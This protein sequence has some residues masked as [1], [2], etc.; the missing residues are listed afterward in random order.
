V[1]PVARRL[2]TVAAAVLVAACANGPTPEQVAANPTST[3]L[4]YHRTATRTGD[5][6][7]S[8][9]FLAGTLH[10]RW[11]ATLDGAVYGE[12]ILVGSTTIAVT[13]NNT[14]YGL[15][16]STGRTLWSR[17]LGTPVP[18][19]AQPCGNINPLGITSTPTY[20]PTTGSLFVVTETTGGV[21]TLWALT[22]TNGAI[23]WHRNLDVL[24]NRDRKAE[25]QRSALLVTG[26]RV[27]TSFGG[28][29]GDCGNYVGYITSVPTSGSGAT[30]YY[31]VPTA[32][33]AGM[34]AAGGPAL[35]SNGIVYVASGN[36][37]ATSP[38]YDGSDSVIALN[39]TTMKRTAIFAPSTWADDNARDL[40]LGSLS[41]VPIAGKILIA[42][43]RGV[44]YL[45]PRTLGGIGGQL[46]SRSG[47]TSFGG[48]AVRGQVVYL[49][50]QEGLRA[51]KVGSASLSFLW[52]A[53]GIPGSPVLAGPAV[54]VLNPS[55]QRFYEL[56]ASDGRVVRSLAL[57]VPI[58]RFATPT[59][60]N[61]GRTVLVGT[62]RGVIAIAGS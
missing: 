55:A 43:K 54:Y 36:G 34:W 18:L 39:P 13:E 62:M 5:G 58:S 33:E 27:L 22:S 44:V 20:D 2:G 10:K 29:A 24:S 50:C 51:V 28:H 26:G 6:G 61:G 32:R 7:A 15:S 42:G 1:G 59:V 37:A 11:S 53:A 17:H 16:T 35:G 46:A 25:Q 12:P 45:L 41:P 49:P 31:A 48:A 9:P 52:Q 21:H 8:L 4:T 57:G 23:R 14:V 56:A 3:W 47:C 38:P 40:D 30:T 19:S 60:A